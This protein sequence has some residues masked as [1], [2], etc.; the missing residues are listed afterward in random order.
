MAP[1]ILKSLSL[2]ASK[3]KLK[4]CK[5]RQVTYFAEG[6]R[7]KDGFIHAKKFSLNQF[8]KACGR[9]L[10]LENFTLKVIKDFKQ[11]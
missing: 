5:W 9:F 3:I 2:L 10:T 6:W 4:N 7:L 1:L 8:Q 11:S